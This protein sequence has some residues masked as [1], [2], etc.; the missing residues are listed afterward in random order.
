MAERRQSELDIPALRAFRA[1]AEA[2]SFAAAQ[3]ALGISQSTISERLARLEGSI[4]ASLC[5]RGRRGFRLTE[6]GIELCTAVDRLFAAVE[7]YRLRSSELGGRLSG[8]LAVGVVDNTT[9]D[10][11]CPIVSA[12]QRFESRDHDVEI[13]LWVGGP[14]ELERRIGTD[15]CEIG[16]STAPSR[17]SG[18]KYKRLYD[19]EHALCCGRDHPLA[20]IESPRKLA[21]QLRNARIVTTPYFVRDSLGSLGM[22]RAA[23]V[24][25]SVEACTILLLSSEYVGYLPA[26]FAARWIESGKLREILPRL[27]RKFP[28]GIVTRG[29]GVRSR[30]ARF[31]L[32][33]LRAA[34][35]EMQ[36]S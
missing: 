15:S 3:A 1:L 26:H 6:E 29:G 31:F 22:E 8:R 13:D 9:T 21:S 4:G 7:D 30:A 10:P 34:A 18:L 5:V 11:A 33:D 32:S 16:L 17:Q 28:I 23:A 35:A 14:T 24:V 19:E 20:G 12:I 27:R 2:G 25:D 36:A